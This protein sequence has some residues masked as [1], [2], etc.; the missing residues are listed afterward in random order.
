MAKPPRP[1]AAVQGSTMPVP[2]VAPIA[3]Y[4][5]AVQHVPSCRNGIPWMIKRLWQGHR[6][7]RRAR[8]PAAEGPAEVQGAERRRGGRTPR[9]SEGHTI[10]TKWS[11]RRPTV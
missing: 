8:H 5:T 1:S 4:A 9:A 11:N 7:A 10:L 6:V 3:A 2:Q